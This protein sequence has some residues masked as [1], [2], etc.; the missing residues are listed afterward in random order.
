LLKLRPNKN[1]Y[2][3]HFTIF[4]WGFTGILGELISIAALP[5]VWYRMFLALLSLL[6]Y[7]VLTGKTKFITRKKALTFMGIGTIVAAHWIFFFGSIKESTVSVGIICLSSTALFTSLLSPL[8]MKKKLS[9]LELIIALII[10]LGIAMIFHFESQYQLGI[11]YGLI[12][13]FM[14]ALFTIINEKSVKDATGS[15]ISAYSMLGGVLIVSLVLLVSGNASMITFDLS[16]MDWFWLV[17]LSTVCT[18][19]AYVIGVHVMKELTAYTVVLT[20]NLEPIYGIIL[21][22]LFF[23]EQE[24]M[25]PGFYFGSLTILLAVFAFPVVKKILNRKF[26]KQLPIS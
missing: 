26:N 16:A 14:A 25:T 12:A 4:I 22:Y 13:A 11:I 9:L 24:K 6:T 18:A 21:A 7:F 15:Q 17:L 5:L 19:F 23:G 8:L 1:I 10:I 20:T 2:L 3:L